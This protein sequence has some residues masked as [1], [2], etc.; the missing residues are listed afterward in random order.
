VDLAEA[1]VLST[2]V[3]EV[4]RGVVVETARHGKPGGEVQLRDPA[5]RGRLE[6]EQLPL[7]QEVDVRLTEADVAH[8]RVVFSL[9]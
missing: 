3:G 2:R 1:L 7:G 8:R 9:A 5:V 4:F 6:G